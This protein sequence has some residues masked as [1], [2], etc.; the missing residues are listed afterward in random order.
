MIEAATIR[1][2]V[3]TTTST[4]LVILVAAQC[5]AADPNSDGPRN[6]LDAILVRGYLAIPSGG[7]P[8][9]TK[10]V[11]DNRRSQWNYLLDTFLIRDIWK[12]LE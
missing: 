11:I 7:L 3:R 10:F 5:P 4:K 9:H 6:L 8:S 12:V 2:Q 1:Y